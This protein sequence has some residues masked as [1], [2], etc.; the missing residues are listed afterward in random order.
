VLGDDDTDG[1]IAEVGTLLKLR[2]EVP[3]LHL[4]FNSRRSV[5]YGGGCKFAPAEYVNVPEPL[6]SPSG[7][8]RAG[9]IECQTVYGLED[10]YD[11][12]EIANVD[13]ENERR[14]QAAAE[15]G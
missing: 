14:A 4:G 11:L 15:N 7:A 3:R 10:I 9:L 1:D 13:G 5:P 12:I 6:D 8:G 2:G